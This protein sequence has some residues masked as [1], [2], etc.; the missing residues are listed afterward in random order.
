MRSEYLVKIANDIGRFFAAEPDKEEAAR[1]VL[2][3]IKRFWDPRMRAQIVAHYRS[4]GEGLIDVVRA[5]VALLA[6]ETATAPPQQQQQAS[7]H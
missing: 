5:A 2:A 6:E 4:G 3:H 1:G 7:Q